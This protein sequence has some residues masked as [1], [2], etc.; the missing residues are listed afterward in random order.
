MAQSIDPLLSYSSETS[1]EQ[2]ATSA[3]PSTSVVQSA[4]VQSL[5]DKVIANTRQQVI[6]M[7]KRYNKVNKVEVFETGDLVRLKIPV[8]DWCSTDYMW[9]FCRV[10]E[11]KHGNRYTLQCQYGILH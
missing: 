8:Q 6:T 7:E 9:I 4:A 11:V 2:T 1:M 5:N 10:I 3:I